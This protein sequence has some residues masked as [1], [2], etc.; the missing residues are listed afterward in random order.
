MM[1]SISDLPNVLIGEF[2]TQS[3]LTERVRMSGVCKTWNKVSKVFHKGET[4][5]PS[6]EVIQALG[7]LKEITSKV[8]DLEKEVE[9]LATQTSELTWVQDKMEI[10]CVTAAGCSAMAAVFVYIP[11]HNAMCAEYLKEYC[12]ANPSDCPN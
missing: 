6:A 8:S 3:D 10:L 4:L 5:L 2:Y 9:S 1:S 7:Q 12:A 11:E